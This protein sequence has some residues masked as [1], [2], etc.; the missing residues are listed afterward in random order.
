MT[1]GCRLQTGKVSAAEGY[2]ATSFESFNR[3]ITCKLYHNLQTN[4][5]TGTNSCVVTKRRKAFLEQRFP[6]W[7][8]VFLLKT[9]AAIVGDALK[10]VW[11]GKCQSRCK[12]NHQPHLLIWWQEGEAATGLMLPLGA[13]LRLISSRG[14]VILPSSTHRLLSHYGSWNRRQCRQDPNSHENHGLTWRFI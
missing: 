8:Q 7:K 6:D 14:A 1:K 5:T 10:F 2:L 9:K 11:P 4:K 12:S 13:S 3:K